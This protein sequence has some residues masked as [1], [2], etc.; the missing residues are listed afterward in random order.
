M[1]FREFYGEES[2]YYLHSDSAKDMKA[3]AEQELRVH[4]VST[5]H[6]PELNGFVERFNQIIVDGVR[7]LLLQSGL[8]GRY[9]HHACSAFF[10]ARNA[11]VESQEWADCVPS[12][13]RQE[14]S[15]QAHHV[16]LEGDLPAA[17]ARC[18]EVRAESF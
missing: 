13:L 8:P 16:R 7:C 10:L 18:R 6:R 4:L 17:E 15:R 9:W 11:C 1:A 14:V 2:F 3:A 5:P 12:T